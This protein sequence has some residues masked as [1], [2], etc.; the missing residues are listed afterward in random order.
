M[1]IV[2]MNTPDNVESK[3]VI[4]QDDLIQMLKSSDAIQKLIDMNIEYIWL[5][6]DEQPYL[7][8]LLATFI[9]KYSSEKII[10]HL[11]KTCSSTMLKSDPT[12]HL[13]PLQLLFAN[14]TISGDLIKTIRSTELKLHWNDQWDQIVKNVFINNMEELDTNIELSILLVGLNWHFIQI[15]PEKFKFVELY[16]LLYKSMSETD[17][18][19]VIPSTILAQLNCVNKFG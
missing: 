1:N 6:S 12:E 9:V 10:K 18:Y 13:T 3:F 19:S 5:E 11:I 17:R 7:V 4:R 15:I 8:Y 14:R 2:L 16:K